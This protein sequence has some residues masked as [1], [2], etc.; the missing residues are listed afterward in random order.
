MQTTET[1]QASA[2]VKNAI[3]HMRTTLEDVLD[4][5]LV[6]SG[7]LTL[8]HKPCSPESVLATAVAHFGAATAT[9]V[10]FAHTSLAGSPTTGVLDGKRFRQSA[11][12]VACFVVC[13]AAVWFTHFL[14]SFLFALARVCVCVC[15]RACV[16][17]WQRC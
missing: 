10:K 13:V 1:A 15:L 11:R 17:V 3:V 9:P 4:Y 6:E 12:V 2:D 7:V 16:C 5:N 14:S 8:S